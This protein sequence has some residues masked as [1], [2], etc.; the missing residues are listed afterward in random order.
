MSVSDNFPV[1]PPGCRLLKHLKFDPIFRFIAVVVL[2]LALPG[3][4]PASAAGYDFGVN[5]LGNLAICFGLVGM[6]LFLSVSSSE[7]RRERFFWGLLS[8]GVLVMGWSYGQSIWS[9]FPDVQPENKDF[10]LRLVSFI[11]DSIVILFGLLIA[12]AFMIDRSRS[13][14]ISVYEKISL[15]VFFLGLLAFCTMS[16]PHAAPNPETDELELDWNWSYTLFIV[17]DLYLLT[18]IALRAISADTQRWGLICR[19]LA[20]SM[21]MFFLSDLISL[22]DF[23]GWI[24][25]TELGDSPESFTLWHAAVN[26]I[27]LVNFIALAAAARIGVVF[28][29]EVDEECEQSRRKSQLVGSTGVMPPMVVFIFVM[30]A[31][32]FGSNYLEMPSQESN[33]VEAKEQLLSGL[34]FALTILAMLQDRWLG[35]QR[36]KLLQKVENY[37]TRLQQSQKLE[38]VGRLVGGVAH[39]FNN[40]IH[41]IANCNEQLLENTPEGDPRRKALEMIDRASRRSSESVNQLFLLKEGQEARSKPLDLVAV[42]EEMRPGLADLIGEPLE[43][44]VSGDCGNS[45]IVADPIQVQSVVTNLVLNA[46]DASKNGSF[47]G[48]RGAIDISIEARSL[49]EIELI[50]ALVVPSSEISGD[51]IELA[52]TDRGSGIPYEDQGRIFEPFFTGKESPSGSEGLGLYKTYHFV[53]ELGGSVAV[54]STPGVGTRIRVFFPATTIGKS[55]AASQEERMVG[56]VPK[57]PSN[58]NSRVRV[59][60]VDDEDDLRNSLSIGLSSLGIEITSAASGHEGLKKFES[61]EKTPGAID[62]VVTDMVMPGMPGDE[63]ARKLLKIRPNLQIIYISGNREPKEALNA[64]VGGSSTFLRKPFS[65]EALLRQIFHARDF[66]LHEDPSPEEHTER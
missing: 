63:L 16:A 44:K 19:C 66:H 32:Y 9:L 10:V 55:E 49:A 8:A 30:L 65:H 11:E 23:N 12:S 33:L 25:I 21:T 22:A 47:H 5:G 46:R 61:L 57:L 17:M 18:V 28:V 36:R 43:L 41:I 37:D 4:L 58:S 38:A 59:L 48:S 51:C 56:D 6:A 42:V 34:I 62:V 60:L 31:L 7:D 39:D 54:D 50:D 26:L 13:R 29:D 53:K 3:F 15:V 40:Q 27:W 14:E 64:Q 45:V 1:C 2:F 20:F 52:V 35:K 24:Q